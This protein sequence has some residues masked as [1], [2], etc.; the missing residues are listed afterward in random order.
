MYGTATHMVTDV[1]SIGSTRRL[2]TNHIKRFDPIPRLGFPLPIIAFSRR[3]RQCRVNAANGSWPW[4]LH[5]DF[6]VLARS[7]SPGVTR[8]SQ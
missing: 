8:R 3:W 5:R 7:C 1:T 6:T 2:A 4:P